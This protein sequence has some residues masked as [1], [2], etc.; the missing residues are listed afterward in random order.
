MLNKYGIYL[1]LKKGRKMKILND[2][3]T[4]ENLESYLL[5]HMDEADDRKSK[6]NPSLTKEQV[7]N[8]HMGAI[9]KGDITRVREIMIKQLIKEFGEDYE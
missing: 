8:I 5:Y 6:N 4:K 3:A 9:I 1:V 2:S 7:W